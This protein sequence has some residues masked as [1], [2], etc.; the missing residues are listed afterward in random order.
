MFGV[1]YEDLDCSCDCRILQ[2]TLQGI[3]MDLRG[4]AKM[5]LRDHR[6]LF[7]FGHRASLP[8]LILGHEMQYLYTGTV[9]LRS[10][11]CP[12]CLMLQ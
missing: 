8:F 2:V 1:F 9:R 7:D 5:E 11:K 10:D 4:R 3:S 6:D 12:P